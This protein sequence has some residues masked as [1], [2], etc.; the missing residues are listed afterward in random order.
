MVSPH[1]ADR[2]MAELTSESCSDN[3][4]PYIADSRAPL[5]MLLFPC[6]EAT[7][8]QSPLA[9]GFGPVLEDSAVIGPDGS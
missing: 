3:L 8:K 7:G 2:K 5:N 9:E 4:S 1:K 6:P